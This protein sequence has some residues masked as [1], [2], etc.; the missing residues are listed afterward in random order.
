MISPMILAE[1]VITALLV[2]LIWTIQILNYPLFNFVREADFHIYHQ[3]HMSSIT[4]LVGPLMI[5]E[6][7]LRIL[8]MYYHSSRSLD[9][10]LFL[11][12]LAVWGTTIFISVPIHNQLLLLKD[13]NLLK[14]LIETNWIRTL[15]WTLKLVILLSLSFYRINK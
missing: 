12:L 3:F 2:G 13:A 7:G 9:I 10:I 1:I 14:K 6:F 8:N 5:I 11:L 4:L 15:G